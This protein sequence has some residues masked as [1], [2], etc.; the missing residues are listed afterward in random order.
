MELIN[1]ANIVKKADA[2]SNIRIQDIF[3]LFISKWYWFVL[4]LFI[5]IG[6]T[7]VYLLTT[8]PVYTRFASI[9]IKE[10]SKGNG[11][12]GNEGNT[13][14]D[15]GM[16]KVKTNVNNEM[17]SIKSPAVIQEV[18]RRLHLN[19]NYQ[20]DGQFH[21]ETLYGTTLPVMV[22]FKK[23]ADN[24]EVTLTLRLTSSK[25]IAVTDITL[26][27]EDMGNGSSY[28]GKI[29][30][31]INTSIG[32][33]TV[34]AT[35]YYKENLGDIYVTRA[36]IV[37]SVSACRNSLVVAQNDENSTIID[38]SY[39]DVNT[40]RAEDV[41]NML[42]SVYNENWVKDKNQI[43][44]S[45]SQFIDERL[46]VIEKELGNVDNDISSYKSKHLVPDIQAA[47]SMYM[48]QASEASAQIQQ[49]NN[50]LYIARYLRNIV[51][52]SGGYQLLPAN[53]GTSTP[54][55]DRDV[56]EYNDLVLQY[57]SLLAS[58]S[59]DNPFVMEIE[60]KLKALRAS[61]VH[62]IDN[63]INALNTQ[64]MSSQSTK[65]QSTAQIASNPGQAKYL[66]SVERQQK[67]KESLYL[68]LLQK[69][70][71]NELSQAFTA[72]NTRVITPPT[73]SLTPTSPE[74]RTLLL[75]ALLIGLAVP[76]S[77]L[78]L[79]ENMNTKVRG[80]K[81]IEH[82]TIPFIGEIPQYGQSG[83][84][85]GKKKAE[86]EEHNTVLV[87]AKSRNLINEAFRVVRSNM[88][89][90]AGAEDTNKVIMFTSVN[91]GSGK[92]FLTINMA[93][94]FAIKDRHAIAIDLDM[95]RASLSKY[96][97]SP[98]LGIANYLNESVMDWRT[99]VVHDE[100]NSNLDI[101]P[102]GTLPPNPAELLY[103][104]RLQKMLEELRQKYDVIF[105]DCPPYEVVAD[106]SIISKWADMTVFVIRAELLEREMLPV[107][108]EYYTEKKFKNMSILLN[109]TTSGIG[110]Y[111]YHRYGYHRYGYHYGYGYGYHE[112]D[113]KK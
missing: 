76:A 14:S 73:G 46:E 23:L 52:R 54:A 94:S 1:H 74:R 34:T 49:L 83:G 97:G 32:E 11:I 5:T 22:D 91:P 38:L 17:I 95:R 51:G 70:E 62:S 27:G 58:S 88:E 112:E 42:I 55:I 107:I 13:F 40:Q 56:S 24:D 98:S 41:L 71:E 82:M 69:R 106:T 3:S 9:L 10:D 16:F 84:K 78:F 29:G 57:N 105:I 111:G 43:A 85:W 21:R 92:T 77:I 31:P 68:F 2:V 37:N 50:Q 39:T 99:I 67:V 36:G 20:S 25:D 35:D 86:T 101:I 79:K 109:G 48:A 93:A 44:Y 45:T 6:A 59:A 28:A 19:V 7:V 113:K 104:P 53:L 4:S 12:S 110:R 75:I 18:V 63:Q 89:F 103:S 61:I 26:N 66:L 102:V 108:E 90:M 65:S 72:Y 47:S 33:L 80:R 15:L 100:Q 8:P 87:K 30:K 96:A 60:S 64:L 81:D